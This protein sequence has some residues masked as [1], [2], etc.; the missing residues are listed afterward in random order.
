M[1]VKANGDPLRA[2]VVA[3]HHLAA[4]AGAEVLA[5]G[6]NALEAMTA[7]AAAIA[8]T[9]PH[10]NGLGGDG[11]WL[12]REPGKAPWGIE[13]CG[14]AA[15]LATPQWYREQGVDTIPHR[16]GLAANTVAGTVSG[17]ALA[18]SASR[19]HWG[20]RLPL[21]RLLAP[22]A[23]LAR[24]GFAMTASQSETLADKREELAPQPGFHEV[25]LPGGAPLPAGDRLRQP[26][27][28]D[29]LDRIAAAGPADFYQG[30]IAT[31]IA[32]E[33]EAAGSPLRR[34]DLSGYSARYVDPLSLQLDD[35]VL[36]NMPPP[37]QGLASMLILGVYDRLRRSH[38][39]AVD[40][41]AYV[42]ALVEA[43]KAAFRV[44]DRVVTDPG[45]VPQSPSQ[46]LNGPAL[47]QLAAGFDPDHAA[48]WPPSRG[49]GD[50]VWLGAIDA[51]G[52]SVSFIQSLFHEFGSGVTMPSL[53]LVWQNRGCSF[54]LDAADLNAL[55]PGR[56]PFH[57][58]N[59]AMAALADGRTVVY[60]T[61]GGEGQPQT[62]AAIFTRAVRHGMAP[63]AAVAAPR[64]LLGKTWGH[65]TDSL[66]VEE[67]L[68]AS[69]IS[70]LRDR[71]HPVDVVSGCN[72]MMGHAGM[73]IR[74]PQGDIMAASDPRCDGG[75]AG[76]R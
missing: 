37:T 44:R 24:D 9:Y 17:W 73:L 38:P 10:M 19:E 53:G 57:T 6:G 2:A 51:Q 50:T 61:M 32:M 62:Q 20:G 14:T 72:S 49:G 59:P 52:R 54:S 68:G 3:P 56:R 71:G 21:S 26:A 66:K 22:A 8:V 43:T 69:V 74:S 7:A 29:L 11:F 64:W 45:R 39:H 1:V 15:A 70:G 65:G 33:L 67:D 12:V 58:L 16:G 75:V 30:D 34:S 25:F 48:P 76:I 36:A 23:T 63:E 42:H 13:A 35:G 47:D 55:E 4:E 5:E 60:G 28:A 27:L 46:W 41:D 40:S 18:E 31:T